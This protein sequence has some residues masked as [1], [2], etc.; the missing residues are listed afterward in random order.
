MLITRVHDQ[1]LPTGL[2]EQS[3]ARAYQHA[4]NTLAEHNGLTA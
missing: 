4:L 1:L 2:A 3:A